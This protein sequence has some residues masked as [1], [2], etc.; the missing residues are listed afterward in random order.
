MAES[1]IPVL[2]VGQA[3]R[4]MRQAPYT[5]ESALAELIDNSLQANAENIAILA[6]DELREDSSGRSISRLKKLAVFDDGDG[7]DQDLLQN[8]LSVGFSR[9]KEDPEGLG[10]FGFGMLIGALSQCYRMEVYSRQNGKDIFHTY[11][12]IPELIENGNQNI[13]EIK[14]VNL[15][16]VPILGEVEI[17]K[18][19]YLHDFSSGTLVVL[20]RLDEDKIKF[21]TQKGIFNLIS[22]NLGRIYRHYLDDDDDYGTKK[23]IEIIG[24]D[25]NGAQIERENIMPNDPTYILTPNTLPPFKR[26]GQLSGGEDYSDK[27]TNK[28]Y[29]KSIIPIEYPI[30]DEM[31]NFNG[32]SKSAVTITATLVDPELRNKWD[33]EYGNAGNSDIGRHYAENQGISIV[34][35][36][37]EITLDS[38]GYVISYNPT[39]RWWGI[40]VRFK[41]ELDGIFGLSNDKQNVTNFI[42]TKKVR[43]DWWHDADEN[44]KKVAMVAID[45]E[46]DRLLSDLRKL[47]KSEKGRSGGGSKSTEGGLI[48][49]VNTRVKKDPTPTKSKIEQEKK[50]REEKLVELKTLYEKEGLSPEEA[51]KKAEEFIDLSINFVLDDWPGNVFF[52]VKNLGSGAVGIIN[53]DHAFFESFFQYLQELDEDKGSKAM[54]ITLMALVRT[55]DELKAKLDSGD[56]IFDEFRERWGF[57]IKEL[58]S[59]SDE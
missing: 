34:R 43:K 24:F 50:S 47:I 30:Y 28:E 3:L 51:E 17:D 59:I 39:E 23:N 27:S 33:K 42:S 40:E 11:I 2:S 6:K 56:E 15:S 49:G 9:N 36:G 54:Q 7:M 46:I 13:P 16:D 35:A 44:L 4:S 57:W 26:R 45:K 20:D 48:S 37:R 10:K 1:K 25:A 38:F 22:N 32:T 21:T 58:I 41:P 55:E 5:T 52:D 18:E 53:T 31:G 19:D 12:D 8:C 29:E 14:S